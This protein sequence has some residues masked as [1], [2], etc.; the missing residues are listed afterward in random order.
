[1]AD[2]EAATS[3]GPDHTAPPRSNRSVWWGVAAALVLA[4]AAGAV[5][6]VQPAWFDRA[7]L[8]GLLGRIGE[9]GHGTDNGEQPDG[10]TAPA[11]GQ[12]VDP[13]IDDTAQTA[14]LADQPV[15]AGGFPADSVSRGVLQ[16]DT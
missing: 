11:T 10:A 16:A 14:A 1:A 2:E 3:S 9:V 7:T 8:T 15:P 5:W 4:A 12:V 6:Y 13:W